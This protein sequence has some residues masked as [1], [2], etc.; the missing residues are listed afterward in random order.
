MDKYD[1]L[2]GCLSG[3]PDIVNT[4]VGVV[5][6]YQD[7]E[8][9]WIDKVKLQGYKAAHPNDGWVDRENNKIHLAYPYFNDGIK[10]GDKMMLGSHTGNERPIEITEITEI[11]LVYYHFK[12]LRK[13]K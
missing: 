12:D 11:C 5:N 7:K 3:R 10:V 9:E 6:D 1:E 8:T 4:W 13:K 2:R